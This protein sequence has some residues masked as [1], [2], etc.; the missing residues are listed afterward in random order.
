[1]A[2]QPVIAALRVLDVLA[3]INKTTGNATVGEIHR[4]TSLDKATIVRMLTTLAH[5]GYIVRD[6]D[7]R[8][9]RVTGKTLQL[10]V[11]YN[12]HQAIGAIVS[13]DLAQF[14]QSIGWPSDV[15]IFDE[16]A[17]LVIETSRETEPMRFFRKPGYRAPVLH[18]SLGRAYLAFCPEE[19]R[20]AFLERAQKNPAPEFALARALD[21]LE[22]LLENVRAR[23]YATMD[24]SYSRENYESKFFS[25]G[26]PIRTHSQV[27]GAMNIIYLRRAMTPD[28]ARDQFL[29]PLIEVADKLAAKLETHTGDIA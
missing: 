12:R 3:A 24:E 14:R 27:F 23:G 18:T 5:A 1:M 10:S 7:S 16:D 2:Y 29:V 9:Y 20:Q 15:S 26:V 28:A 13:E 8:T 19:E 4:L 22:A 21:A 17:M 25:I 11:G 6:S